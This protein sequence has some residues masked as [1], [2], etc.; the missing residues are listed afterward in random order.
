[1]LSTN[2]KT[3]ETYQLKSDVLSIQIKT[4]SFNVKIKPGNSNQIK[5]IKNNSFRIKAS[6]KEGHLKVVDHH[7]TRTGFF[8]P[9]FFDVNNNA[10]IITLKQNRL[11]DLYLNNAAGNVK[12]ESLE[13]NGG[14]ITSNAG[15]IQIINSSIKNTKVSLDAGNVKIISSILG[16]NDQVKNSA[17]INTFV[18]SKFVYGYSLSISIGVNRI[19]SN[20]PNN[21][22]SDLGTVITNSVGN[23]I[24][25]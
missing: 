14:K 3:E 17:G 24:I 2:R 21:Y 15:N 18:S 12:L 11:Q 23:N 25:K 5:I 9:T 22:D 1:M 19:L 20:E 4:S 13:I 8:H 7:P 6:F 16:E 10:I